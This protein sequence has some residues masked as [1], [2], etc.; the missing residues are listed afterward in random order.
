MKRLFITL[1]LALAL[2]GAFAPQ[3]FAAANFFGPIIPD[4]TNGQPDCTCMEQISQS[5]LE[6]PSAPDWGCVMQTIQNLI[7]LA[8]SLSFIIAILYIVYVGFMF[9]SS[10]G[11]PGQREAAKTRLMNVVIGILVVL[12]AWLLVDFV[13]KTLYNSEGEFGPWNQIL[14]SNGGDL[15]IKVAS[16]VPPPVSI[17]LETVPGGGTTG[18]SGAGGG[19]T[20]TGTGD[21][22]D[23][24]FTYDD[25]IRNQIGHASPAL[26]TL[27]TCMAN[28]L[29][30]N[31][32]NISSI[33]DSAIV[34][35]SATFATCS[36]RGTAAGCHHTARSCHFGGRTCVG[37]SYAVDF[38]DEQNKRAITAAANACGADF[39][40]DEGNHIHV[41]VGQACGCDN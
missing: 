35:A 30:A 25:G 22:P 23:Q 2:F 10:A 33:S 6:I 12:S 3:T 36:A 5:G 4:G 17:D 24:E 1:M 28:R 40:L 31:V 19:V 38:G 20:T 37:S 29:P 11:S 8:I 7:N 34:N 27:L 21:F 15:C 9:V 16:G 13:M 26:S 14:A 41:S 39:V 32:G 18:G